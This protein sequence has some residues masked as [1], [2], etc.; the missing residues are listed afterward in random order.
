MFPPTLPA[1]FPPQNS[2]DRDALLD[3][4]R[5]VSLVYGP[6]KTFKRLYKDTE[7]AFAEAREI[8]IFGALMARLERAP[9]LDESADK[10]GA[11]PVV[12]GK[13][14]ALQI[15]N[16]LLYALD[17]QDLV[18]F[19][20]TAPLEPR[21]IFRY[22]PTIESYTG[23]MRIWIEGARLVYG[24]NYA[25]Q[26]F[27][28]QNPREPQ[29]LFTC[30]AGQGNG[31]A[32]SGDHVYASDYENLRVLNF[33]ASG[34]QALDEA[35]RMAL[36]Y[37]YN[38][39]VKPGL[40]AV[41]HYGGRH[42]KITFIDVSNPAAPTQISQ[43]NA[44]NPS[45]WR[46]VGDTLVRIDGEKIVF[47]DLSS[48]KN[49]REIGSLRVRGARNF[50]VA[51]DVIYVYCS[52]WLQQNGSY[53]YENKLRVVDIT[54]QHSP[55]LI[56]EFD[57]AAYQMAAHGEL[58][59]IV[60][61]MDGLKILDVAEPSRMQPVGQRPKNATFA[62]LKRRSRRFLRVLAEADGNAFIALSTALLREAGAGRDALV[63]SENWAS[64]ELTLGGGARWHQS[65]HGRGAYVKD[66][67]KL[68]IK[69]RE[70]RAPQHWD[71]H[72]EAAR[73][74][75]RHPHLPWQ[76]QEMALKIL[77]SHGEKLSATPA[78]LSRFL[79]SNSPSLL[80][81]AARQARPRLSELE[82]RAFGPLLWASNPTQR[83]QILAFV[84]QNDEAKVQTATNLA[85]LLGLNAPT[86]LTR[87]AREIAL[88]LAA[89]FDL[90]NPNF[91]SSG[92]FLAIPTLLASAEAPLRALGLNF[93]C[94]L[95]A[96]LALQA[97]GWLGEI[98]AAMREDFIASLLESASRGALEA[99]ELDK[100]VRNSEPAI[101][102]AAWRVIAASQT[103]NEALRASW[104]K[105]FLGLRR[106]SIYEGERYRSRYIGER[107][108]E[109]AALQ[110][111]IS[112]DAAL[113]T[114]G[115]CELAS[116]DVRPR[117]TPN[118]YSGDEQ[119]Q[120]SPAMW[121]AYSLILPAQTVVE[122][123]I[124]RGTWTAWQTAWVRANRAQPAQLAAFWNAV[125][126]YLS[127][128]KPEAQK[129]ILRER[130]FEQTEVAATFGGA[131]SQLSPALLMSLIGAVPDNLWG[132]W[133]SALLLTLQ[134]DAAT[135]EAFWSAARQSPALETGLLRARLLEDLDFAATFGLL[136]T[137]ALAADNPAF[138]PLILAWLRARQ[139]KLTQQNWIEAAIHPLPEVRDF[140]LA[141]LEI[142][143]L[144]VSGAL[145]L[146]ESRLPPSIDFGQRWFRNRGE[147]EL[148]SALALC[149][150]PQLA[151]RAFGRDFIA[152]H[153]QTLLQSGL[154]GYLQ[155][156]PNA[157]MQ[158]FVAAQ[159]K[160]HPELAAP[161]FD[162]AVL[163]SRQRARHAKTLI[164][165]RTIQSA[166]LAD[167]KTLLEIA[168]S[169][170]P[171]DAEW[172][173][174]QLARRALAG[175]AVEGVEV[176]DLAGI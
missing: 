25:M 166:P 110:T 131:A 66:A 145:Q 14:G 32:I 85:I 23:N 127:S 22:A 170:T 119:T 139:T 129:Q 126:T 120:I 159:L 64:A 135:R 34:T 37:S 87:R 164:Q 150:S 53:G 138:T 161:D 58:L 104:T 133:R 176:G 128:D 55:R 88:L 143:G 109:S 146:L 160:E 57:A 151:V 124:A 76:T 2:A 67:A 82:T 172:A 167:D 123:I 152:A 89:R 106:D 15:A 95:S 36:Q 10:T 7:T 28:L 19:D 136:E 59:Y 56:G 108:L 107:W 175:S 43:I 157:E 29:F 52:A 141:Q 3:W 96:P 101:R 105:L 81:Y 169:R 39:A 42:Y 116:N 168:R 44:Q 115:R 20:L 98:P 78:Q 45:D 113:L 69:K 163:R 31:L 122:V 154:I 92:A 134:S 118:Q 112:S 8:E 73:E 103:P 38:M 91:D 142:I 80:N 99:A 102:E 144:S 18:V 84:E 71:T 147:G 46:F 93:C 4:I 79:W 74:L 158:S 35:G 21:E 162:R 24:N 54:Q 12:R 132:Q 111:A 148:E 13:F 40:V 6:W 30:N 114:L 83:R 5:G 137:D 77:S 16:G 61:G 100:S 68:V 155:D 117:F 75:W 48:P 130:T 121:G 63:L 174:G 50:H 33:P 27:D 153:F 72:L 125:Q 49:P 11:P 65:S 62:Y 97:L 1:P 17:E 149:D 9:F 140:G 47:T 26:V 60:S 94:R 86:G 173:L 70:E 156:N 171:R 51:G 41:S 165:E 90:S